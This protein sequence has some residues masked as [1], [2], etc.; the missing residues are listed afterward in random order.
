VK[1]PSPLDI[2][3]HLLEEEPPA[4]EV[5]RFKTYLNYVGAI[6]NFLNESPPN[7]KHVVQSPPFLSIQGGRCPS[8]PRVRELLRNAWFTEIQL[9][10]AARLDDLVGYSNHWAPVQLYYAAYLALRALLLASNQMYPTIMWQHFVRS[11]R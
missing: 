5:H 3:E 2:F 1:Q 7:L 4:E 9:S 10:L 6:R 11:P 8:P